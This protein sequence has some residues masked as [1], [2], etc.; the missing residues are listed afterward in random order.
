M[1]F[2]VIIPCYNCETTLAATVESVRAAGLGDYE[3]ILVDD[4]S[5]D[6]TAALCDALSAQYDRL[7]CVHQPNAGV[8]AARNRGIEEARGEYIWFVDADDTVEALP[9]EPLYQALRQKVDCVMFG[10]AF[11]YVRRGRLIM[12]DTLSCGTAMEVTP[13]TLGNLFWE[14]FQKNYFTTACNKIIRRDVLLKHQ[15]RF[16]A[17]LIN[18]EDLHFSL[19]LLAHCKR[20]IALPEVCYLY[21][22]TF[23]QD[24]TAERL[25]RI[26]DVITYTDQI[27]A[28]FYALDRQL[29]EGGDSPIAKLSETVLR[30]YME[31]AYFK[32]KTA[33]RKQRRI[34]C[35]AVQKNQTIKREAHSLEKLSKADQHLFRWLMSDAY[36][37][38]WGFM[39][40]RKL[41]SIASRIYRVTKSYLRK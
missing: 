25:R 28:P 35:A 24:H 18:Y 31:A 39:C 21:I 4:G 37:S 9:M 29:R 1:L 17:G 3:L 34:L 38:M 26:P 2:S 40:Y 20:V 5:T 41:R 19:L 6:G 23:G 13:H 30:L 36:L 12:Q 11:L 10:M 15:L 22:N 33:D 14:L 8:S 27:V 7:R 16:D 32:L